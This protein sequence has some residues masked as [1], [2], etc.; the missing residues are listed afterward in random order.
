G[1]EDFVGGGNSLKLFARK[2]GSEFVTEGL[3][4]GF[5]GAD[6]VGQQR[7]AALQVFAKA[8]AFDVGEVG[9]LGAVHED[10]VVLEQVWVADVDQFGCGSD[11]KF[12][13]ALVGST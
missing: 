11:L 5:A 8:L 3:S 12:Q 10:H 9:L 1:R 2:R 4:E 6:R 7:A 13:V